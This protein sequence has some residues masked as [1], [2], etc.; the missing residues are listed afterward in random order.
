MRRRCRS[1]VGKQHAAGDAGRGA[2]RALQK[3]PPADGDDICGFR[4][5]GCCCMRGAV[6]GPWF[7]RICW[8]GALP[9]PDTP[10]VGAGCCRCCGDWL[11]P[12]I[13]EKAAALLGLYGYRS[14]P[15]PTGGRGPQLPDPVGSDS[16]PFSCTIVGQIIG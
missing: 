16:G 1:T 5:E 10:S 15:P 8:R 2:E 7:S 6:S 12:K 13:E 4:A 11:L 14:G 9:R 3:L